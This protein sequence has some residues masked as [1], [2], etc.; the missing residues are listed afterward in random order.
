MQGL[1]SRILARAVF[2][3]GIMVLASPVVGQTTI[4]IPSNPLWTDTGI[5]VSAGQTVTISASGIW[6]GGGSDP[7]YGPDGSPFLLGDF[8]FDDF[9]PFD[10]ADEGRLLGFVGPDPYQGRWGDGSFFPQTSGYISVG[11][12]RTFTAPYSGELWLGFNNDAGSKRSNDNTGQVTANIVVGGSDSSGPTINISAPAAVYAQ[13]QKVQAKYSCTDPDDAV[14]TCVGTVANGSVIDTSNGGPYAFTVAA[15]DSHGNSSSQTVVYFVGSAGLTPQ[16]AKFL[17][18]AVNTTSAAQKITL[19]NRQSA[20]LNISGIGTNGSFNATSTCGTQLAAGA[21]CMI[22]VTFKPTAAGTSQGALYVNDSAGGRSIHLFGFGTPVKL[23][24]SVLTYASQTV[25]TT[26]TARAVTLT[27]GQGAVLNIQSINV[28]GDF[29]LAPT[30]T[31]PASG[32]LLAGKHCTIGVTF[33]PTAAGVRSGTLI[34][35]ADYPV[36][37]VSVPLTGTGAQ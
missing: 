12:G 29:A 19:S 4:S 15:S 27:N 20:P 1:Y 35:Q 9:E 8:L 28:S 21:R 34:I 10:P 32:T 23:A 24:P 7:N 31:C 26:S 36:A 2:S 22:S 37:P 18:Q 17:P 13:H 25:G 14:A 5:K 30:T 33:M 3:I 16:S 6:N 11:S